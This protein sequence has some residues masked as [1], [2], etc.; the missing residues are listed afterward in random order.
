MP[1]PGCAGRH[2]P[3]RWTKDDWLRSNSC[4]RGST[5]YKRGTVTAYPPLSRHWATPP[6]RCMLLGADRQRGQCSPRLP[7][8]AIHSQRGAHERCLAMPGRA[9]SK[10]RRR[11]GSA[12]DKSRAQCRLGASEVLAFASMGRQALCRLVTKGAANGERFIQAGWEQHGA[13]PL[14]CAISPSPDGRE[15]SKSDL[16]R[17]GAAPPWTMGKGRLV[18]TTRA[19]VCIILPA[20]RRPPSMYPVP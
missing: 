6:R 18:P 8:V 7:C 5:H 3:Q 13:S 10:F 15:T 17:I 19:I 20:D 12:A 9:Q 2:S 1:L 14:P 16:R 11:C 4:E